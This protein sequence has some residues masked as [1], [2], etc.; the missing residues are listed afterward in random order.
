MRTLSR[1]AR[2]GIAAALV[3]ALAAACGGDDDSSGTADSGSG[4]PA[5]DA[6]EGEGEADAGVEADAGID[7]LATVGGFVAPEGASARSVPLPLPPA[8]PFRALQLNLCNSGYAGCFQDGQSIPEGAGVIRQVVPDVV[9]LN[10]ICEDDI[11]A[12]LLPAMRET[13]PAD[14]VFWVFSPAASRGS[15][16]PVTCTDGQRYG[17]AILGHVAAASWAGFEFAGD[18]LS[19]QSDDDELRAWA[20]ASATD[21]YYTCVTHLENDDGDVALA[22]CEELMNPIVPQFWGAHGGERPTVVGGDFNLTFNGNPDVQDCV[23]PA[24]YRKGDGDVQ[25]IMATDNLVFDSSE[26]LPMELTD[27]DAW[28]VRMIT[29]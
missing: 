6:G 25:H 28:L 14:Y 17:V 15:G 27:H 20:C 1:L 11:T 18:R 24:W 19:N 16:G 4:A 26:L 3:P 8:A 9:T 5:A 23:P 7:P 29:P 12:E 13:W 2:I 10:E 22:Q 21:N